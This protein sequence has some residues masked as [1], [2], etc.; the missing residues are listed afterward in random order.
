LHLGLCSRAERTPKTRKPGKPEKDHLLKTAMG[1][2]K[3]KILT[4]RGKSKRLPVIGA[5]GGGFLIYVL[6]IVQKRWTFQ[7]Y[8]RGTL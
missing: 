4:V 1:L 5:S 3:K 7:A 2:A 8:V 6:L